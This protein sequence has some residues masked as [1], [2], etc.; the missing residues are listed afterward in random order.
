MEG[1]A[2]VAKAIPRC[3]GWSDSESIWAEEVIGIG[4]ANK[5][6]GT[7]DGV[8]L[9]DALLGTQLLEEE[10]LEKELLDEELLED[11]GRDEGGDR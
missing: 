10:L 7:I 11:E 8:R 2:A 1:D 3:P 6:E 4:E 9:E 5:L